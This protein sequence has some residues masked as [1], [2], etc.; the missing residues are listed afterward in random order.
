MNTD[1]YGNYIFCALLAFRH[2]T[3]LLILSV[4]CSFLTVDSVNLLAGW[5]SLHWVF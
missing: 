3:W 2:S 4:T 1:R 5:Y